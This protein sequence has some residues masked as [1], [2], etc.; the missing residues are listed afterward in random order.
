MTANA[1]D[2]RVDV[3]WQPAAGATAYNVYRGTAAGSITTR[4]S[5]AGGIT[6]TSYLDTTAV[7]GTTYFYAVRAVIAGVE[8]PNSLAVQAGAA[9]TSCTAGN[10]VVVENCRPGR[11][12]WTLRNASAGIE[13]FATAQSIDHGESVGLKVNATAS[14]TMDVEI[15]RTGYYGGAGAR[16]LSTLKSI[17]V[18]PQPSC[19]RNTTLGLVDCSN[20]SVTATLTT[21]TSW[22][23]GIYMLR[24]VRADN[25]NDNF[26][27]LAVRDD[28][29]QPDVLYGSAFTTFQ[30]YNSWGGWSLYDWNSSGG[31]TVS[32]RAAGGQGV[33]RPALQ[34]DPHRAARLVHRRRDR[35]RLLA[36]AVG[37]RRQL[38]LR[39]RPRVP[40]VADPQRGAR[41]SRRRHDEY[42]SA[43]MRTR[44]DRGSRRRR[45]P[46]LRGLQ[47]GLLEDPLRELGDRAARPRAGLLQEHPE[48][49]RPIPAASR[50]APGA[51]R[52]APTIRRTR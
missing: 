47:R 13:G 39:R 44:G 15:Y 10:A 40:A 12:N 41:T 19:N 4:V 9:A 14:T 42:W 35:D 16:L 25:A 38:R 50:R 17:P 2:A 52:P 49:R 6:A 20:W 23:S 48:R 1:L 31:N 46:V 8:S 36:R 33:L 26:I 3:A 32:Q 21:S 27:I 45:Q 29:R 28:S 24:I 43:G 34:P 30:A 7:N 22:T 11:S 37:L 18:G 5:P 51:I